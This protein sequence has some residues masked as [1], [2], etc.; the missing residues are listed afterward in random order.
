MK[1]KGKY[2]NK[3]LNV[4]S[5]DFLNKRAFV[6]E[7]NKKVQVSFDS[8]IKSSGVEDNKG[9]EIFEKDVVIDEFGY[10]YEVYYANGAFKV[11]ELYNKIDSDLYLAD[12]M[13]DNIEVIG[14]LMI[15]KLNEIIG[16]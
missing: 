2:N 11:K 13:Q 6:Q 5:I 8:L 12:I 15:D 1:L 10:V 9:C 16:E 7:N 14:N 3:L 4:V